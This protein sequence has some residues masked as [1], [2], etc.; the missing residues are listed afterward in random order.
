MGSRG[1]HQHS[2]SK[3]ALVGERHVYVDGNATQQHVWAVAGCAHDGD[4]PQGQPEVQK[5]HQC[6]FGREARSHTLGNMRTANDGLLFR[7]AENAVDIRIA[8]LGHGAPD[9]ACSDDATDD[10][11]AQ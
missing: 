2:G 9:L 3:G 6:P 7:M 1:Q 8:W 10:L 4:F 5:P 11:F